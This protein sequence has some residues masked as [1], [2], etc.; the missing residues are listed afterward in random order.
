MKRTVLHSTSEGAPPMGL[1]LGL[2]FGRRLGIACYSTTMICPM[3]V[4][5]DSF[6]A[7]MPR[8]FWW[9]AMAIGAMTPPPPP[10]PPNNSLALSSI[11]KKVSTRCRRSSYERF[12][13]GCSS[14]FMRLAEHV[15]ALRAWCKQCVSGR[16]K[17]DVLCPGVVPWYMWS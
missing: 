15:T 3:A 16:R 13:E 14:P 1:A 7:A 10:A 6:I 11:S 8:K 5:L 17:P 12:L 9:D 2:G 4:L